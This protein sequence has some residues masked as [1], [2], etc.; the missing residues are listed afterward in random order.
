[1]IT[2]SD[3][4]AG[5]LDLS[6]Y[7]L[8]AEGL[9]SLSALDEIWRDAIADVAAGHLADATFREFVEVASSL[10]NF[11]GEPD[12]QKYWLSAWRKMAG[13]GVSLTELI[14]FFFR[15]VDVCEAQI[16]GREQSVARLKIDLFSLLRRSVFVAVSAAIELDEAAR[17]A[18]Q[19]IPGELAALQ[20]LR[21][22]LESGESVA[23]LT[24]S[25]VNRNSFA[26]LSAGELQTL[27]ALF[28]ERLSH[29]LRAQD[30]VFSGREGEWL[31][32]IPSVSSMV[33]P[34]LAGA[35][36]QQTFAEPLS[37]LSGRVILLDVAIG[38]AMGPEQGADADA[39][40][41]AARLARWSLGSTGQGFGWYHPDLHHDWQLRD[42]L[43]AELKVALHQEQLQ[44]YL[45]PQVDSSSGMCCG[46][47][48]LLRWQRRNGDW[49]A[50]PLIIELIEENGWRQMFTECLVRHA[51]RTSAE[52]DKAGCAT[53]L[54]LNLT[55]ADMVDTDLPE[56]I[57]QRLETWQ[58]P[59]SRFMIELTE[60]AMMADQAR[61][62]AVMERL[63]ELGIGLALD[64]FGTGYS[65]LSYLVNL[66]FKEI[67]IDRSFIVAMTSSPDS[68]RIVRT[69]IDL[70][71]DLEMTPLAEGVESAAQ[72]AQLQVLGCDKVQG[73]LYAKPMPLDQFIPWMQSRS[74]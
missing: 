36:I 64:D 15:V 66:P 71:R 31:L 65:S 54:S 40:L 58:I 49:V 1:M 68:L 42:D 12:W 17:L 44:F 5:Y 20:Y 73:Y 16:I 51:M 50:P 23:L 60:S 29:R 14:A 33:Q 59:G 30:K 53:R 67:K 72:L 47:E 37:L 69:I 21:K 52:L 38:A 43:A 25:L 26:H 8:N 22:T 4:S 63:A 7:G 10:V 57:A 19:G 48:M 56:M 2:T 18:E 9:R 45:Q 62:L 3:R 46:A 34:S 41:Q 32:V 55:A 24:V 27:P 6:L 61:C 28:S 70:T 13:R 39:L 35:H 11:L 74:A